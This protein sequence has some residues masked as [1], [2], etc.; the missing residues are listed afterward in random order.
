MR[1]KII[2]IFVCIL[3]LITCIVPIMGEF[4]A[5]KNED[6]HLQKNNQDSYQKIN[7][8]IRS[9]A[10]FESVD[11]FIIIWPKWYSIQDDGFIQEPYMID[12]IKATEDAVRVRINVDNPIIKLGVISK[13]TKVGVPLD[14]ITFSILPTS[15]IWCGDYGPFFIEKNEK[16]SIVDF[17]YFG[18]IYRPID[19][20]YPTFYGIQE[21]INYCFNTNFL[22]CMCGG[23]YMTDGHGRAMIC[24]EP[25]HA[26]NIN[27]FLTNKEIKDI[28]K[29]YL[30]LDEVYIFQSQKNDGT[31]HIDMFAK[32]LDEKTVLVGAW[33]SHDENYQILEDNAINFSHLG[34][35]VIRIPMLRD[36]N[37]ENKTIWSYVNSLIINGTHK[38]VVLVPQY[39][40]PEDSV[41]ISIYQQAM[42]EYEIRGI[43]C[44]TIIPCGGAIHCTTMTRPLV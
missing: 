28:L 14:N 6:K 33:N 22:L 43:D 15:S 11:E 1:K 32:L 29:S 19:N 38:K 7:D 2:G 20:L 30:G 39:N 31:G 40:I 37:S 4:I 26:S 36:P 21:K 44:R 35:N 9:I 18:L 3:L 8:N 13:L 23:N 41:A 25:L 42:P 12:L 34:F 17:N 5:L 10:E 16:L 27:R 24:D